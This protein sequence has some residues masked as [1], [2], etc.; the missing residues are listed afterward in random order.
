MKRVLYNT[1]V[2]D[3]WA[4]V[5]KK[6]QEKYGY[7]PV[8]WIGYD[9]IFDN[10]NEIIP[11][12]FP[13]AIFH[14]F[15]N[16]WKGI[17]PKEITTKYAESYIDIDFLKSIG[18]Q[19]LQAIK[20]MDRLDH[21]RYSFNHM[22]RERHFLN[23]VKHWTAC[24]DICKPDMVISA[25]LPHRVYDYV[26]YLLCRF[27]QIPFIC[28][29]HTLCRERTFATTDIFS[30]GN[31]F[32]KDYRNFQEQNVQK[33][34]LPEEIEK[35]LDKVRSDYDVAIPDY[36]QTHTINNKQNS[37]LLFL[38]KRFLKRQDLFGSK[39]VINRGFN[40]IYYKNRKF[41][42]EQTHFSVIEFALR[43]K[44][45]IKYINFLKKHYESLASNPKPDDQYII[46]FLHYQ[47]E[48]TTSPSGDIFVNQLLCIETLLKHTPNNYKIY[49][50]EHPNQFMSHLQGQTSRI[51]E[52]YDDLAKIPRVKMIPLEIDSYTLIKEAKAVATVTGTVGWE[53]AVQQK[54]V[55]IFGIIWY[56][57]YSGVLRITDKNSASK[58]TSF[59]ENYKYNE[60]DLLAYLAAFSKN[61]VRAYH[62]VGR[63]EK[64][65]IPEQ[66]CINNLSK[67]ILKI[68]ER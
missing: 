1:C 38:I 5:A 3:P 62:Y 16:A 65:N 6:L 59:L 26:L 45:R 48:A 22:E 13:S 15:W 32:D 60:A 36:M 12:M 43:K 39:G 68:S 57:K 30:I 55:I 46:F 8:Y 50:K 33:N 28:F 58:I 11:K 54:P 42:L 23:L 10:S 14:S 37:N 53:A 2:V 35:A 47:P 49:V 61:T 25:V 44:N 51:K 56:E 7:E 9:G 18:T 4:K 21:D 17:F 67:E 52:F 20:M 40:Q 41:S 64:V 34:E 29:H 31:I 66:E 19:E 63:K 27:H 24:L